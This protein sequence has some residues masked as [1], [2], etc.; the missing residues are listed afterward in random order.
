MGNEGKLDMYAK[1]QVGGAGVVGI[2]REDEVLWD[3]GGGDWFGWLF[4]LGLLKRTYSPAQPSWNQPPGTQ[5]T[6]YTVHPQ[7]KKIQ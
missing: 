5:N 1:K 7:C 3:G 6:Y 2:Y 4:K